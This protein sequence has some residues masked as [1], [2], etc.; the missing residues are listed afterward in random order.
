M[1]DGRRPILFTRFLTWLTAP[2]RPSGVVPER[3]QWVLVRVCFDGVDPVDLPPDERAI[4]RQLFGDVDRF[5]P[6]ARKVIAEIIGGRSGKSYFNTL[7]LLHLCCTVSLEGFLAPGQRA[8]AAIIAPDVETAKEAL[9]YFIGA[10]ATAPRLRGTVDPD[11]CR[12]VLDKGEMVE[13]FIFRRPVDGRFVEVAV[14]AVR[15]GGSNVRGRWY[16][17]ALMDEACLFYTDGYRLNDEGPFKAICPRILPGGQMLLSSTPWLDSGVLY[18]LWHT[19]FGRPATAVVAH[20][21]TLVLRPDS[22]QVREVVQ[23]AYEADARTGEETAA[24]EFGAQFGTGAADDFLPKDLLKLARVDKSQPGPRPG[25]KV[26]AGGDLA[27][28]R[29][30]SSL[31]GAVDDGKKIRLALVVERRPRG[32]VS[33]R[34][35]KVCREF[36][37]LVRLFGADGLTAD[38]HYQ[39][40]LREHLEGDD[41][42][43]E[44]EESEGDDG[45]ESSDLRLD[46]PPSPED[47]WVLFKTLLAEGRLVL[48]RETPEEQLLFAQLEGVKFRRLPKKRIA[49][50]LP[51]GRDGRHGDLAASAV[52][53]VWAVVRRPR[54]I[55]VPIEQG[56]E[57]WERQQ[58]DERL[59]RWREEKRRERSPEGAWAAD[60][61]APGGWWE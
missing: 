40:T 14:R 50:V 26:G 45:E 18:R 25:E 47:A 56:S 36:A 11:L 2:E 28:D 52:L 20:A 35:S 30:S 44:G 48:P 32:G 55:P 37:Q 24:R 13:K 29:N 6:L 46:P 22:P 7:R 60:A 51:Q 57:A 17:G 1:S 61:E 39:A 53:A 54:Q 16:V 12:R 27:F 10:C 41:D 59:A 31:V 58:R 15:A 3:G 33:L 34:P 4:A 19:E 42:Q 21:P 23:T 49:I 43:A 38:R 5:P 9:V 8:H